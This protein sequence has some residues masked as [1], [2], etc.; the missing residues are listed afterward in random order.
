MG[1]G[2]CSVGRVAKISAGWATMHLAPTT[3]GLY[4]RKR[5]GRE[6]RGRKGKGEGRGE[7]VVRRI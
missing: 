3:I 1:G 4:V 5:R 7:E 6:E 2:H